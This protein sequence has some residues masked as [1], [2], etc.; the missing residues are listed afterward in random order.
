MS[1]HYE[2]RQVEADE[3]VLPDHDYADAFEGVW[4][5]ADP[6]EPQQWVLRGMSGS[7]AWVRGVVRRIGFTGWSVV[8]STRDMVRLEQRLPMM[9]VSVVGRN[10]SGRRRMTTELVYLR[11]ILCR[12]LMAV[13]GPQH[14]RMA[15]RVVT[16][17]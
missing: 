17:K 1:V 2:V 9:M 16:S 6:E 7:P 13:I 8:E 12:L 4:D 11:P 3:S 15:K 5:D 14:R 10:L